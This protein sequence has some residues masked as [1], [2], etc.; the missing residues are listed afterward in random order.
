M[1]ELSLFRTRISSVSN[2]FNGC[3]GTAK[4]LGFSL[5]WYGWYGDRLK[6]SGSNND[7]LDHFRNAAVT[8]LRA[9]VAKGVSA[10]CTSAMGCTIGSVNRETSFCTHLHG[11]GCQGY[12]TGHVTISST[13]Q[14]EPIRLLSWLR[15]SW[16]GS[17]QPR[18]WGTRVHRPVACSQGRA[19]HLVKWFLVRTVTS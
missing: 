19:V 11:L 18:T 2:N 14:P 3:R 6:Q 1:G 4:Y 10:S 5:W 8:V 13:S 17:Q 9:T 7:R 12:V 15:R 16:W